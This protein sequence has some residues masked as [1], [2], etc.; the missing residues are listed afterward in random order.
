MVEE[1]AMTVEELRTLE[2]QEEITE[3]QNRTDLY[4]IRRDN[5]NAWYCHGY[6]EGLLGIPLKGRDLDPA[7]QY[8]KT[9]KTFYKMGHKDGSGVRNGHC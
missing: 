3:W 6:A 5:A 7:C 8:R 2:L 9:W 4:I 1:I